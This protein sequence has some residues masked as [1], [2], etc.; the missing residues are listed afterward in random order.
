MD[1][2]AASGP[3]S[4]GPPR[5]ALQHGA[6]ARYAVAAQE[7]RKEI[8]M[9]EAEQSPSASPASKARLR[10]PR[11]G[12][13]GWSKVLLAGAA[14]MAIA[15]AGVAIYRG[16]KQEAAVV[17]PATADASQAPSVDDVIAKLEAKLKADP[18]NAEGWRMLGWSYFQTERY[19][20]AAT[21]LKK[22]TQL[23]PD[24]AETFSFLGEALVLASDSEGGSP[25]AQAAF[26]RALQLDP[27]DARA[28]FPRRWRW[29]FRASTAAR[30]TCGSTCWRIP[31][32]TRPMPTIS[33]T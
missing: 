25:D 22:A 1:A 21:A 3:P 10:R 20:E 32:P 17:A 6:R 13:A 15:A 4:Q 16:Q 19:A 33:A 18:E 7:R 5:I 29:T 26:D 28:V 12:R 27:K 23:D 30:S 9:T 14:V 11:A 24:H 31:R 8:S 2:P